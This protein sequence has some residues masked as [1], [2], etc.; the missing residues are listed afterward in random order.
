MRVHNGLDVGTHAINQQVH[1]DFAGDIAASGDALAVEVNDDHVA[2]AHGAFADAGGR[3]QNAV[4]GE[5][6]RQ[7]AVHG[8]HEPP[9]VEHSSVADNFIPMFTFGRHEYPSGGTLT[10]SRRHSAPA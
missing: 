5:P 3:Y 2:R 6:D 1:A 9:L 10:K 7:I 8:C 4:S